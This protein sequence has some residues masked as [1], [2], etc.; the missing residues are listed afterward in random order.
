M[1]INWKSVEINRYVDISR[2]TNYSDKFQKPF[3]FGEFDKILT[4]VNAV[5]CAID[6]TKTSLSPIKTWYRDGYILILCKD[7]Y[8]SA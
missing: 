3:V 8:K 5:H 7:L 6:K 4:I 2:K 1:L